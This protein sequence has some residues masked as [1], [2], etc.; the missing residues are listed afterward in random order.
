MNLQPIIKVL[1]QQS[2]QP[3]FLSVFINPFFFLR[4]GLYRQIKKSS[5]HL[6]GEMLDFG[7]GRKPYKNLFQVN[8]YVGVDIEVSGHPHQNS[9]IDVFYDGKTIPFPD[10]SFDSFF[11]SEVFEH[12]FNLEEIIIELKRIL[13]PGGKGLITVPFAWPEHESPYDFARYTSF[14]IRSVLERNGLRI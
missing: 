1:K 9:E 4:K 11:C 13:K 14:G 2:F 5:R 10:E 12:V 6:Q 8:K 3:N 7:C